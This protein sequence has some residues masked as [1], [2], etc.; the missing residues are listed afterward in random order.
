MRKCALKNMLLLFKCRK[1]MMMQMKRKIRMKETRIKRLMSMIRRQ[2]TTKKKKMGT[3]LVI[4]DMKVKKMKSTYTMS[5]RRLSKITK[6]KTKTS[7]RT[8]FKCESMQSIAV[9]SSI[10]WTSCPQDQKTSIYKSQLQKGLLGKEA[11][12][13]LKTKMTFQSFSFRMMRYIERQSC[14]L[15][16]YERRKSRIVSRERKISTSS[17]TRSSLKHSEKNW[18]N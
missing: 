4:W 9:T 11:I 5:Q 18:R 14:L 13:R 1:M 2:V 6:I 16:L 15:H 3:W 17:C 12:S 10:S 8:L 7:L